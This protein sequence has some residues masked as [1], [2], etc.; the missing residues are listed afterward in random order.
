MNVYLGVDVGTSGAKVLAIRADG[1]IIASGLGEYPCYAPRPLWS[2]QNPD[3]WWNGVVKTVREVLQKG[4][5]APAD[6]TGIRL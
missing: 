1:S 4:N 3:D 2:E 6:V 5:I